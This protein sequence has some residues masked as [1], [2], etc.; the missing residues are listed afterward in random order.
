MA[1]AMCGDKSDS[2]AG[3]YEANISIADERFEKHQ[4]TIGVTGAEARKR[5]RR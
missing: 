5:K 4:A 1:T 3:W 2:W